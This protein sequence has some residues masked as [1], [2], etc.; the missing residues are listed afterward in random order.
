ML[1]VNINV[2]VNINVKVEVKVKIFRSTVRAKG[3][4]KSWAKVKAESKVKVR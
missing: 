2:Q 4:C 1:K 3:N